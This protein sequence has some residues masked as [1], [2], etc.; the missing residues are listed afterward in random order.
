M[1]GKDLSDKD[2]LVHDRTRLE[3]IRTR[4]EYLGQDRK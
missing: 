3:V 1:N 4:L 2:K